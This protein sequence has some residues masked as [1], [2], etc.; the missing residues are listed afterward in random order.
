MAA[1][2]GFLPQDNVNGSVDDRI[3]LHLVAM[4]PSENWHQEKLSEYEF[5]GDKRGRPEDFRCESEKVMQLQTTSDNSKSLS[6]LTDF[7]VRS[8]T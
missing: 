4:R 7:I 8:T 5:I 1:S 2:L 3:C 6:P